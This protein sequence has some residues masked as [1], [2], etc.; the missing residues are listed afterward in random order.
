VRWLGV[1]LNPRLSFKKHTDIMTGKALKTANFLRSLNKTQK[2]SPPNA[3]AKAAKACV[4]PVALYSIKAW[5]PGETRQSKNNPTKLVNTGVSNLMEK[6]DKPFRT[7]AQASVPV[8]KT[9]NIAVI[10]RESGFP[11]AKLALAQARLRMATRF[12]C[13]DRNHPVSRRIDRRAKGTPM[14]RLQ[15]TASLVGRTVRP[16]LFAHNI[17]SVLPGTKLRGIS[18]EK[19]ATKHLEML[20]DLPRTTLV[21]YSDRSQDECGNTG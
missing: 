20:K 18:K 1:H 12:T 6:I 15:R 7:A 9:T 16:S 21:A 13:L 8:W 2:G 5:W 19:A 4:L 10:H 17:G 14:T 3:V 11:R